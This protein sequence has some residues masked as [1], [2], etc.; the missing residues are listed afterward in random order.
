MSIRFDGKVAIV[1]GAGNGL[2]R[3]YAFFLASRGAK[4]VVNDLGGNPDGKGQSRRAAEQVA[5]GIK[6]AGGQAVPN[7]DSV[8]DREQATN[9]IRTALESYGTLDILINNAGFLRDKAFLNMTL[10]DFEAV[11]SVH[12]LGTVYVTKAAFPVMKER[13]YGRIVM[14]TS[15]S[16]LYGNY[17]QSNYD[18]AKMGVIGLMN[19]LKHEGK[20]YNILV[21]TVAPLAA[22]RLAASVF[23]KEA[24]AIMKPDYVTAMVAYLCSEECKA[25]GDI[26]NAGVG[27]YAL[28]S[29]M[30]SPGIRFNLQETVTP[31]MISDNYARIS[32]MTGAVHY[33]SG[34]DNTLAIF[35]PLN[36]Q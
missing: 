23:P 21:N 15:S 16:G 11:L 32:D 8:S 7:F 22:S 18:A 6:A 33:S 12:L 13:G 14:V 20:K 35:G 5:D 30:E 34:N 1:T 3:D 29:M 4:V 25:S 26:I 24:L 17:G 9:I 19:A 28:A 10:D 27:R 31:E 36:S 2:G